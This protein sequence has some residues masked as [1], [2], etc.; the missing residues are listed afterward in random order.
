[1][2]AITEVHNKDA[3]ENARLREALAVVR[4]GCVDYHWFDAVFLIDKALASTD[5]PKEKP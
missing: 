2:A 5:Q 1:M 3:A 4:S